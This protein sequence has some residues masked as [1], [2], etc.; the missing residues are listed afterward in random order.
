VAHAMAVRIRA[1]NQMVM[2][3]AGSIFVPAAA[4][5]ETFGQNMHRRRTQWQALIAAVNG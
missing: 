5:I 3:S 2:A 4:S 1:N